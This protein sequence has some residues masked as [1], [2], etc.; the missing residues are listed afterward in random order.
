MFNEHSLPVQRYR[1][2]RA[3]INC[4]LEPQEPWKE[5]DTLVG[6]RTFKQTTQSVS[7][8]GIDFGFNVQ[9]WCSHFSVQSKCA[10][11]ELFIGN[12]HRALW[13]DVS[14]WMQSFVAAT[15]AWKLSEIRRSLGRS[16]R[17]IHRWIS[18]KFKLEV[19][20]N[21]K[22]LELID[23][24][25]YNENRRCISWTGQ[26]VAIVRNNSIWIIV[27][28][29]IEALGLSATDKA[30]CAFDSWIWVNLVAPVVR[31]GQTVSSPRSRAAVNR[32]DL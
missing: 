19:S 31:A 16:R 25:G 12:A 7:T 17:V 32:P 15:R 21:L 23:R 24:I 22:S 4:L 26:L 6:R 11:I 27:L 2:L 18:L 28:E 9:F 14:Q 20:S 3:T 1:H 29:K 13:S 30:E 8:G 10:L 5:F